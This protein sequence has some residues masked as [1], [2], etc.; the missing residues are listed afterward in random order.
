M[1]NWN[2]VNSSKEKTKME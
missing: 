1:Q 2:K